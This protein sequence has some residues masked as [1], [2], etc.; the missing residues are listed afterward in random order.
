[1]SIG[2]YDFEPVRGLPEH[3][4][5]GERLLWQGV[6]QTADLAQRALHVRK[7]AVYFSII[8]VWRAASQLTAGQPVA[9]VAI[10]TLWLLLTAAAA[11]GL[12]SLFAWLICRTTVYTLTSRRLVIRS[13]IAFPMTINI[14]FS[15]VESADLRVH[16]Q[17]SGD[18]R[19]VLGG[20]DRLAYLLL[21]PH[22]R[23]W[24]FT[25][26]QPMLRSLADPRGVAQILADALAEAAAVPAR[27]IRAGG[28]TAVPLGVESRPLTPAA[29]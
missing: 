9:G 10:S 6:P 25:R 23:P 8:L 5:S 28:D 14:P 7:L 16:A 2:E 11:I 13:G 22:A 29:A 24:R 21:W 17:G 3:L 12:L 19:L 15:M 1:M 4:P 18:I 26:T 20:G 27:A